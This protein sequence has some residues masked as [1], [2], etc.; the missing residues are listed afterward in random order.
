MRFLK[1]LFVFS[2]MALVGILQRYLK[3]NL[4]VY[5]AVAGTVCGLMFSLIGLRRDFNLAKRGV[6]VDKM[7]RLER[8]I[9]FFIIFPIAIVFGAL[10]PFVQKKWFPEF[11]ILN[12]HVTFLLFF[13][14]VSGVIA[15][16]G[17]CFLERRYGE[18]F[19]I[20]KRKG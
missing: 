6:F 13:A 3:G 4:D 16:L 18:K 14:F 11:N 7:S 8:R 1:M 19:Y 2:L 9:M 10:M 12:A 20:A 5:G 15:T 17:I